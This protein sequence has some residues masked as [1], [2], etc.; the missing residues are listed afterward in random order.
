[1]IILQSIHPQTRQLN[2]TTP[3]YKIKLTGLWVNWWWEVASHDVTRSFTTGHVVNRDEGFWVEFGVWV[4]GLPPPP[5]PP[6]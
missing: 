6:S 3:C 2:I 1:M 4:Q 5:P